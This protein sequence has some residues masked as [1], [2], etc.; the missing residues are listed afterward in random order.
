[1]LSKLSGLHWFYDILKIILSINIEY[2]MNAN[3]TLSNKFQI[4]IPKAV[5][6][7]QQWQAGQA[8]KRVTVNF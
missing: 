7:E 6:D 1:M 5:R 4:S 2:E 8:H 3:A